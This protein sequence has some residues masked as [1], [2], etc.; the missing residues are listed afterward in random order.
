MHYT[1]ARF[2]PLDKVLEKENGGVNPHTNAQSLAGA[3]TAL[4]ITGVSML[5]QLEQ[6]LR[7][8]SAFVALVIGL[9]TLYRMLQKK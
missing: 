1:V 2:Q 9:V 4:A 8:G 6:W 3:T 7:I 5:P